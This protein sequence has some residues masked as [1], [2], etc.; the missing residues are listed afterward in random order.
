MNKSGYESGRDRV[1]ALAAL[2]MKS[3]RLLNE[4]PEMK[5]MVK[6]GTDSAV[7]AESEWVSF[8]VTPEQKVALKTACEMKGLLISDWARA[9]VFDLPLPQSRRITIPQMNAQSA[10]ALNRIGVNLNQLIR[11]LNQHESV[12]SRLLIQQVSETKAMLNQILIELSNTN[13]QADQ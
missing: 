9:R 5:L 2:R 10:I 6:E 4:N 12:D 7:K 3:R 1:D 13:I 11:K 8:R